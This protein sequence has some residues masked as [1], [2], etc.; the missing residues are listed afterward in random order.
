MSD[1]IQCFLALGGNLN[2]PRETQ[3][4]CVAALAARSDIRVL[5]KSSDYM[6]A[7]V[8]ISESSVLPVQDLTLI[9]SVTTPWFVNSVLAIETTLTA[10]A[11]LDCCLSLERQYGRKREIS[12]A[13]V[14]AISE[15]LYYSRPIDIDLLFYGEAVI[16]SSCLQ[17]P[18]PRL[19]ERAFVLRPLLE[20]APA[21]MHPVL[22]QTIKELAECS[23]DSSE[24]IQLPSVE[25]APNPLVFRAHL[26]F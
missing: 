11:L 14:S 13:I 3:R 12:G 23:H 21:F 16:D 22:N 5:R 17:I 1:W 24:V 10:E 25:S 15:R 4:A 20:I 7:P 9:G 26:S 19:T 2:D 6:T 18:H 8:S